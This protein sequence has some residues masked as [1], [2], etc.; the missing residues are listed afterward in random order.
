[1]LVG[2]ENTNLKETNRKKER[3]RMFNDLG[4]FFK[5]VIV[6]MIV[7]PLVNVYCLCFRLVRE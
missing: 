1:M 7:V 6:Q 3:G 5:T 4:N 2:K